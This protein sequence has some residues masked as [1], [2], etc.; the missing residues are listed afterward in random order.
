MSNDNSQKDQSE[1]VATA[2]AE[3][4]RSRVGRERRERMIERLMDASMQFC[5][6]QG[7]LPTVVDDVIKTAD[8]SRGTFYKYF[9]SVDELIELA[10][11]RLSEQS[12]R[13]GVVM[14][15][16]VDRPIYRTAV[17]LRLIFAR[18][19]IDPN[20]GAFACRRVFV[21]RGNFI[22]NHASKEYAAGKTVGEYSFDRL[23]TVI[24]ITLGAVAAAVRRLSSGSVGDDYIVETS[25]H[26]LLALGARSRDAADATAAAIDFVATH[27]PTHLSWWRETRAAHATL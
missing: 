4:A 14:V 26:I 15:A 3:D 1:Q 8:V 13:E 24:D 7:R 20:W 16:N 21:G 23:D 12:I 18:S 22:E 6:E 17:G 11:T 10:G 25:V 5:A 2:S 9:D 27:G 19:L